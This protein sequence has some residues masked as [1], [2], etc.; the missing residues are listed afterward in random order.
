LIKRVAATVSGNMVNPAA[1]ITV[2]VSGDNVRLASQRATSLALIANEL[3][4]NALEHGLAGRKQ[5]QVT[6]TLIHRDRQLRLRVED[7][8]CG[9]P[10]DFDAETGLGLGLDIVRTAVTEDMRGKFFIG[11]RKH[12]PGA[13]VQITLPLG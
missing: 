6:I 11:P 4:Q 12:A 3:L 7:D 5:G 2:T 10:P 13:R 8:G 9:L 1:D